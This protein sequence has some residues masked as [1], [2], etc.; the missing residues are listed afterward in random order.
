MQ[1]LIEYE[2]NKKFVTE[3]YKRF[4]IKKNQ[5]IRIEDLLQIFVDD[6]NQMKDFLSYVI[7]TNGDNNSK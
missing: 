6:I 7:E 1:A 5:K 3:A 2:K 4:E